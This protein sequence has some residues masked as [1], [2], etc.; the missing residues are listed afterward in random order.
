MLYSVLSFNPGDTWKQTKEDILANASAHA[1]SVEKVAAEGN[2]KEDDEFHTVIEELFRLVE[3]QLLEVRIS[4]RSVCRP[5]LTLL[6]VTREDKLQFN[7]SYEDALEEY[8]KWMG[9]YLRKLWEK[10]TFI[11]KRMTAHMKEVSDKRYYLP[12]R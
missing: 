5:N 9:I 8:F 2:N 3:R 7:D 11:H 1:G 4:C 6:Q 12:D 10:L